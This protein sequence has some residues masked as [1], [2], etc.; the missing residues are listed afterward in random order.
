MSYMSELS[1][2]IQERFAE[3]QSVADISRALDIPAHWVTEIVNE[4]EY[5]EYVSSQIQWAQDSAD[6]DAVAYGTR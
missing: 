6:A 2:E 3:G 1:I 5:I 4:D